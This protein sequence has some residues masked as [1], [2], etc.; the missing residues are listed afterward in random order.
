MGNY[1]SKEVYDLERYKLVLEI[2]DL[3]K[4]KIQIQSQLDKALKTILTLQQFYNVP[5]FE[6][7]AEDFKRTWD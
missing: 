1:I 7:S 2:D 4:E 3:V 5:D 6:L